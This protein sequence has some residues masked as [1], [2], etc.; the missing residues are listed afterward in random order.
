[1]QGTQA[2]ANTLDFKLRSGITMLIFQDCVS[3][4]VEHGSVKGTERKWRD[5]L[6]GCCGH[7]HRR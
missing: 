7:L 5:Q 1:M 4:H 6:G 3:D 2:M